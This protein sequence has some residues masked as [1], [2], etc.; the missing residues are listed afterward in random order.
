[1]TTYI[2]Y[3]LA[4]CGLMCSGMAINYAAT[5]DRRARRLALRWLKHMFIFAGL[6]LLLV[7]LGGAR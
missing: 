4:F 1:M 7:Y 3:L 6:G 2:I 5:N